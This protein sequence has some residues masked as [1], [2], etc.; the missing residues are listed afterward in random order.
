MTRSAQEERGARRSPLTNR[1]GR[2][3]PRGADALGW[4]AHRRHG[5]TRGHARS[6]EA[7]RRGPED[8]GAC[9]RYG[10]AGDTARDVQDG[11]EPEHDQ[12][13]FAELLRRVHSCVRVLLCA[14]HAAVPS[15]RR[16]VGRVCRCQD[17]RRGG[18]RETASQG[19]AGARVRQQC[20]R[21]VAAGRGAVP[22]DAGV[23][24]SAA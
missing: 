12:R 10:V 17:E 7:D 11:V 1:L 13:V 24:P 23:L 16:A 4:M 18:A 2:Q 9:R 19:Q 3:S 6:V 14:V 8:R 20:V 15:A 5:G 22:A 21:R